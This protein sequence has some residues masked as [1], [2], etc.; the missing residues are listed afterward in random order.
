MRARCG[1]CRFRHACHSPDHIGRSCIRHRSAQRP[2]HAGQ[3]EKDGDGN[4]VL[5]TQFDEGAKFTIYFYGC[6]DGAKC[7]SLQFHSLYTGSKA[8]VTTLNQFNL[9]RRFSR[10]VIESGGEA[11]LRM[12]FNLAAGG[13]SKALFLYNIE[14]WDELM[15]VFA[16][17]IYE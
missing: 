14:L 12:D 16:E 4:P 17:F 2:R 11:G 7:N 13:M 1:R 5:Q 3:Q 15:T 9:D 8:T 6:T 10:A